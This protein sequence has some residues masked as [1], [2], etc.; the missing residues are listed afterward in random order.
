MSGLLPAGLRTAL[1]RLAEGVSRGDAAARA[2]DISR[3]YRA[4]GNSA[5]ITRASDA[6]AYALARM[7]ATYAAAAACLD[8]LGERMPGF[9]PESLLDVGAG[10]GTASWAAAQTFDTLRS[11]TMIDANP[12]LRE[13]AR[14]LADSDPGFPDLRIRAGQ[15]V[16][17][18]AAAEPADL[19]VAS[20]VLGELD[21]RDQVDLAD[22]MWRKTSAV[23]L[24][25]EPGTPAGSRRILALRDRLLAAG[26]HVIAPCPADLPCPLREPDWCHFSVRLARSRDHKLLKGAEAPFEDEK[27]SYVALQR[28]PLPA[29]D[30]RVLAPPRVGKVEIAAKL[31][32]PGGL[33]FE[34]IVRRNKPGYAAARRWRWGDAVARGE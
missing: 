34:T 32:T 2:A 4:G 12:A 22:A 23:L 13:L 30:A 15:A 14:H 10:P 24:V 1:D 33:V 27:F 16:A 31:C 28:M 17:E 6:L 21:A 20:Y 3:R 26:A 19:V 9:A 25:I 5:G 29:G 7:P 8:A 18:V 11:L